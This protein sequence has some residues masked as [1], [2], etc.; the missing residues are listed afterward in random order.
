M[1]S[2][3]FRTGSRLYMNSVYGSL[4]PTNRGLSG[5][6]KIREKRE[7]SADPRQVL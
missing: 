6:E 5:G 2:R 1:G 7:T 4:F 3:H